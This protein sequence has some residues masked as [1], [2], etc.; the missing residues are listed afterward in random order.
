MWGHRTVA[1]GTLELVRRDVGMGMA[2][3]AWEWMCH[4]GVRDMGSLER[5]V[6]M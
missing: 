6:G 3:G 5:H 4:M 2:C 1:K